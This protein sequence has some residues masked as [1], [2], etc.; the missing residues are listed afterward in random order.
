MVCGSKEQGTL[1]Q[2]IGNQFGKSQ[3]SG[4]SS[5]LTSSSNSTSSFFN[6][7]NYALHAPT[8]SE[9]LEH[10]TLGSTGQFCSQK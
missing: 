3:R 5:R 4:N 1:K 10:P 2:Q 8:R 7:S 6:K 9:D